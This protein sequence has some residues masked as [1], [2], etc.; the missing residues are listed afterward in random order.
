M[1]RKVYTILTCCFIVVISIVLLLVFVI[2]PNKKDLKLSLSCK[3]N[4][5]NYLS[6]SVGD[7]IEDY[8][9]INDENAEITIE[10]DKEGIVF[11]NKDKIEGLNAGEV[12]V[13]IKAKT[14]KESIEKSFVVKVFAKEEYRINFVAIKN[15]TFEGDNIYITNSVFQFRLEVYDKLNKIIENLEYEISSDNTNTIIDKSFAT[16]MIVAQE[17]CN[18]TFVFNGLSLNCTKSVRFVN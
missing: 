18:L 16:V 2:F 11:I 15:C 4:N 9:E 1:K 10:V 8:Y 17:N 5:E 3:Y 7:I 13:I 6:L 12:K 14:S